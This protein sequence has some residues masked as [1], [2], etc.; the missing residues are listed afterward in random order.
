MQSSALDYL[1][2]TRSLKDL[3]WSTGLDDVI[4]FCVARTLHPLPLAAPPPG[5]T[6]HI[7]DRPC[8][9]AAPSARRFPRH[10][11]ARSSE[12][13]AEPCRYLITVCLLD[14]SRWPA[15]EASGSSEPDR[16]TAPDEARDR[17]SQVPILDSLARI[18]MSDFHSTLARNATPRP[19]VLFSAA[20]TYGFRSSRRFSPS[21]RTSIAPRRV[22]AMSF[23]KF[24]LRPT[25]RSNGLRGARRP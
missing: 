24:H 15:S 5:P 10:D 4:C 19:L 8:R 11:R 6:H 21:C 17:E 12:R 18:G 14:Q 2:C 25:F 20:F 7:S 16:I 23:T 22:G 3:V 1:D 13:L 9:S